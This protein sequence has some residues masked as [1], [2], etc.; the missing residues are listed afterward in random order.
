MP[1]GPRFTLIELLVVIAIIAI[2][3][4]LLLPSLQ[5]SRDMAKS[6]SCSSQQK[7][8]GT[9][10]S[11]YAGDYGGY[12]PLAWGDNDTGWQ[13][14]W[15][16]KT[17]EYLGYKRTIDGTYTV[18]GLR[19]FLCPAKEPY[20]TP[21]TFSIQ[22]NYRYSLMMGSLGPAAWQWPQERVM[23]P[24]KLDRFN[25]PSKVIVMTDGRFNDGIVSG[26]TAGLPTLGADYDSTLQI[27]NT[28]HGGRAN[29]LYVDTH[30]QSC[31]LN[32]ISSSQIAI[33]PSSGYYNY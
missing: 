12:M 33:W 6:I 11:L 29:C 22:T 18:T 23:S 17:K 5:R 27:D 28:R 4:A 8:I 13:H 14:N 21:N 24:K 3:A 20:G 16:F 30:V 7:Q 25:T 19:I 1:S 26:G 32:D 15:Q 9:A 2:L 31:A 10:C